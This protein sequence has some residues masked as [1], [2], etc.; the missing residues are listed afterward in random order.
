MPSKMQDS[1]EQIR[2]M[3]ERIIAL[4]T[5][6]QTAADST[7]ARTT[8]KGMPMENARRSYHELVHLQKNALELGD[9][10]VSLA[11]SMHD[12][13]DTVISD[14]DRRLVEFEAQLKSSGRWPGAPGKKPVTSRNLP[15]KSQPERTTSAKAPRSSIVTDQ[16][17]KPV[18]PVPVPSTRAT[19]KS[20]NK[21]GGPSLRGRAAGKAAR[22]SAGTAR[23][24]QVRGK[25]ANP[26]TPEDTDTV[27]EDATTLSTEGTESGAVDSKIYCTCRNVSHG[28]M[29]GCEGENC[30]NE[31]YHFECVGLTE[32]PEG[33][34]FCDSCVEKMKRK[35]GGT[36]RK[37]SA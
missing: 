4:E 32:A 11:T 7:I 34:W 17:S 16:A 3:D 23:A 5:E 2:Q 12:S 8:S 27:M 35:N 37:L 9:K 25:K 13:L 26:S 21:D 30:E 15:S 36:R 28:E 18:L 6:A 24:S 14:M 1:I 29:I 31:W 20:R 33:A 22:T 10:K 19:Q